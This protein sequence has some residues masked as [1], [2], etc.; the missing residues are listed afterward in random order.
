MSEGGKLEKVREK[1]RIT[2]KEKGKKECCRRDGVSI[3]DEEWRSPVRGTRAS[4]KV[5]V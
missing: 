4:H 5:K 3:G 2:Q 1:I